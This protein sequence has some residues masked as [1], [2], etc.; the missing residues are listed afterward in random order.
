MSHEPS[1]EAPTLVDA[2]PARPLEGSGGASVDDT[3]RTGGSTGSTGA[4]AGSRSTSV[5]TARETLHFQEIRNTRA[6]VR[7]AI[8]LAVVVGLVLVPMGGDF[9]AKVVTWCGLA[10][11]VAS[12]VWLA[13]EI[14]EDEGFTIQKVMVSAVCCV[15]AA[16]A[17]IFYFGPLSPAVAIIPF[18]LCFFSTGGHT[19]GV[20]AVYVL[21]AGLQAAI[22]LPIIFGLVPDRG[23]YRAFGSGKLEQLVTFALVEAIYLAT[24]VIM[25]QSR[26]AILDAIEQHDVALASVA[27]REALLKEARQ[28]L[29]EALR[30]GQGRYTN[31]TFGNFH[32]GDV[33][34]RGAMGEVYEAV[35]TGTKELAAVKV[36]LDHVL[37]QPEHVKR[38]HREARIAASLSVPNVVKVLAVSDEDAAIPY[39]AMERLRGQDLSDWLREHRKMSLRK[40]I[41]LVRQVGLGLEAARVAGIV[42]RDLKPRNVF[43]AKDESG[44]ERWKIL[45]F[46]VSKVTDDEGTLTRDRIVGTPGYM[47]PE[48][49]DGGTV[50]HRT[51]LFSLGVIVYRALTGRPAF[52]GDTEPQIFYKVLHGMPPRPSVVGSLAEELDVVLAVALAK[53]REDRFESAAAFA[54]ALEGAQ[55]GALD[56]QLVERARKLEARH[57]WE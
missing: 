54:Q 45:D 4:T 1:N 6:F 8:V 35:H 52:P 28:D 34:G 51:D 38:F 53:G 31:R 39:L 7:I 11:V 9:A 12:S 47:A 42:H 21:C 36:L 14:R 29:V 10:L 2:R 57:P 15:S 22:S 49:I 41:D 5:V 32:L 17:A 18:G 44:G 40:V 46:G 37:A 55:H 50:D 23:L 20:R 33:I 56:P 43:L 24:Y 27:Q 48:Q 19:A 30:G 16:F 25:R 3:R 13:R 26:R